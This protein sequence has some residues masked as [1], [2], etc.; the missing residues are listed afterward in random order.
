VQKLLSLATLIAMGGGIWMA[1]GGGALDQLG[2]DPNAQVAQPAQQT[3]GAPAANAWNT[4]PQTTPTPQATIANM[5]VTIGG[6]APQG[7]DGPTIK[8]ASFNIRDFGDTKM[9]VPRVVA[10]L[11]DVVRKFD[12][13]AIQEIST[14]NTRHMQDFVTY[15]NQGGAQ[16]DYVVSERLGNSNQKE[17][18]AYVFNTKTIVIDR[19]SVYTVGDPNNL[20]SREPHVAS[21]RTNVDPNAAFTFILVNVHTVPEDPAL[22]NEL[23][24]LAEVYRVVRRSSNGED[25]VIMLGDFNASDRKMAQTRLG[26]IPG[27]TCLLGGNTVTNT[28]QNNLLDNL[29]IHTASTSEYVGRSGVYNFAQPLNLSQANAETVSDHFPVWAEFSA[30]ELD[31]NGR[32]ANRGG[33]TVR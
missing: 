14:Q 30:Y 19:S 22:R 10:L 16:Y 15:V 3:A 23:D 27:L 18:Y 25:D 11:A 31:Y 20:L 33:T 9:R 13:V 32:V 5:P 24:V 2:T 12:V 8:I 6:A 29:L 4:A 21:F 26:M 28:R 7:Q 1:I 17:Q